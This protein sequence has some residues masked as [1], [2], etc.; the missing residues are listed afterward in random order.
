MSAATASSKQMLTLDIAPSIRLLHMALFSQHFWKKLISQIPL[1][2]SS[3]MILIAA[4]HFLPSNLPSFATKNSPSWL[5]PHLSGVCRPA[6]CQTILNIATRKVLLTSVRCYRPPAS[7]IY[8]TRVSL[9]P[10][11]VRSG[12]RKEQGSESSV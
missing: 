12:S 3:L 6:G 9:Y 8:L 4:Q 2:P 5:A 7:V 1:P 10:D 11:T